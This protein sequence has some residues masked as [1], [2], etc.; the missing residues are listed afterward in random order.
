[1]ISVSVVI[2]LYNKEKYIAR[3]LDSVLSQT[4]SEFECIIIDSS[5]DGSTQVVRDFSDK[6]IRHI[7]Q[8]KR[9]FLPTARNIGIDLAKGELIAFI[10]ADDEWTSD[11]LEILYTLYSRFPNSGIYSTPYVK[12]RSDGSHMVMIYAGIPRPPWEGII[13]RYFQSC[14][15][16]DVPI[17]SSSCAIPKDILLKI[18]GFEE[19]LTI[20]GEDQHMWGKIALQYPIVF[21]WKGTAIYH[22]EAEGRMCNDPHFYTGDPLSLHLKDLIRSGSLS[23]DLTDDAEAYIKRRHKM[24]LASNLLWS[25]SYDS[26]QIHSNH[27]I[28]FLSR[29]GK[30]IGI[31]RLIALTIQSIYNSRIHNFSRLIWCYLH[32]WYVPRL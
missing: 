20:G 23:F 27:L 11:H 3:T 28:A 1:M 31:F 21:S 4:L 18:G 17:C 2:P 6:R 32:G 19:D 24:I 25:S 15:R 13:P 10:D 26:K 14:A 9:T 22:T 29:I 7:I 12:L 16:G 5:N 30:K 8:E